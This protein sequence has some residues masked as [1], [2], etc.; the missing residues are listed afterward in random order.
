MLKVLRFYW[1]SNVTL[2][3][4]Y[5]FSIFFFSVLAHIVS[6]CLSKNNENT[7]LFSIS[8]RLSKRLAMYV[9]FA[10]LFI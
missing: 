1:V 6:S 9:V 2:T 7:L 5:V 4:E 10:G 3:S 8:E